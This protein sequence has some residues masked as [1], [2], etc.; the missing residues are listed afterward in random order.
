MESGSLFGLFGQISK[1]QNIL[2]N[3]VET[4]VSMGKHLGINLAKLFNKVCVTGG[5]VLNIAKTELIFFSDSCYKTL[6]GCVS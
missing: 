5:K 6:P 4:G 2:S 3:S 1:N